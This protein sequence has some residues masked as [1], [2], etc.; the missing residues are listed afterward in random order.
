M[1][2]QNHWIDDII[3]SSKELTGISDSISDIA[4]HISGHLPIISTH[5]A[6]LALKVQILNNVILNASRDGM[7]QANEQIAEM[8]TILDRY[9]NDL[10]DAIDLIKSMQNKRGY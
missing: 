3:R 1:E 8:N 7:D 6:N 10:S 4:L 9:R 5:L 2:N